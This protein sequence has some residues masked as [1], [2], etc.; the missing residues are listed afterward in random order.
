MQYLDKMEHYN[1]TET[2]K[3]IIAEDDLKDVLY[4]CS[5]GHGIYAKYKK[6]TSSTCPWCN[7]SNDPIQGVRELRNKFRKELKLV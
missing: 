3:L 6:A 5:N 1:F 7:K 4:Y 2:D